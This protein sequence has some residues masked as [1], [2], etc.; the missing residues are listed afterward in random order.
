MP[1]IT[2]TISSGKYQEFKT[3]FLKTKPVPLDKDDK[4]L[5]SENEWVL[6]C[7]KEWAM[8]VYRAGKRRISLEVTISID[9]TIFE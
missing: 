5:Y 8:N 7:F 9:E 1:T 4:P 2:L 3:G 6:K